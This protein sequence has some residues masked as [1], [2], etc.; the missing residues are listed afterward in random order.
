MDGCFR[1][2]CGGLTSSSSFRSSGPID[3]SALAAFCS[4]SNS[5]GTEYLLM[6]IARSRW[7]NSS[8]LTF[9]R[10]EKGHF[11]MGSPMPVETT[12]RSTLPTRFELK[13]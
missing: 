8:T 5:A 4:S 12:F 1:G 3:R 10:S 2:R 11:S 13:W 6:T 9:R 7:Q